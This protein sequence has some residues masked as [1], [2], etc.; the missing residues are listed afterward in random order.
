IEFDLFGRHLAINGY[1]L[2]IGLGLVAWV[3]IVGHEAKRLHFDRMSRTMTMSLLIFAVPIYLGGKGL[4]WLTQWGQEAP[5]V[6]DVQQGFVFFGS[7]L[8]TLPV[9]AWRARAVGVG[10]LE[11]LDVFCYGAPITHALGRIGCFCAGCCY[12][13]R[14]EQFWA[15]TFEHGRGLNGVAIHPV[16]LYEALGLVV[17]FAWMWWGVRKRKRFHGQVLLTYFLGYSALRVVT[18]Y[19]RGDPGRRILFSDHEPLPGE[20]PAG[21]PTS[22]LIALLVTLCGLVVLVTLRRRARGD[23]SL[24]S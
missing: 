22:V 23:D 3:K 19:F 20:P 16:Q 17:L 14:S 15:V 7:L 13:H 6:G 1:G 5:P 11:G 9:M 4:Y 24:A 10:C 18:E 12:G 2:M 8:A 21:L